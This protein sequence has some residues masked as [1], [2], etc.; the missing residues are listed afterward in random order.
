MS[1]DSVESFR[2][3]GTLTLSNADAFESV[4]NENSLSLI[5]RAPMVNRP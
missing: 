4:A 1:P 2:E 3:I 5:S